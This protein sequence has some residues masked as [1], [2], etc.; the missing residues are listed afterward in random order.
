MVGKVADHP[1]RVMQCCVVLAGNGVFHDSVT[2]LHVS[3]AKVMRYS[4]IRQ[5]KLGECYIALHGVNY[6][7]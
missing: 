1:G 3:D 6:A 7:A 2:V 4:N 5:S